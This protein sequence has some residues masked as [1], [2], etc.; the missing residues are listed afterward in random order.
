MKEHSI[1]FNS[2]MVRAIL[3]GRKIMTRW[4]IAPQPIGEDWYISGDS[5]VGACGSLATR[6][7]RLPYGFIGDRL[8]VKEAFWECVNNND[9]IYCAA[10]ETPKETD[11]RSY[12]LRPSIFMRRADSRI[13]LGVTRVRPERLWGITRR[14]A[15][16]EGFVE[17]PAE[18]GTTV[19]EFDSGNPI[20]QF[21]A[22]WNSIYAKRGL[23]WEVNPLVIV[24]EFERV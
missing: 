11:R 5:I 21:R 10:T 3:D 17:H 14:D 19:A 15:I 8:W 20:Y 1:N 12:R 16:S 2:E 9:R 6:R 22:F 24:T 4:P 23:G 18:D 13:T 7:I